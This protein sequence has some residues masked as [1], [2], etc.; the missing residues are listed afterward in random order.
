[1][2]ERLSPACHIGD[3]F[4][5]APSLALKHADDP[6]AGLVA[7]TMAG[8]DNCHRG[9]VVGA[10]L[11]AAHGL[12]GWPARWR[13]GLLDHARPGELDRARDDAGWRSAGG[14]A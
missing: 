10:L 7:N 14:P 6:A 8:G 11:D 1:M 9:V 2:G 5:A 12:A 13:V 3:A 4:P